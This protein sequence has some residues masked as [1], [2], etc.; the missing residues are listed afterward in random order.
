MRIRVEN[1][2]RR[3]GQTL[4]NLS[5]APNIVLFLSPDLGA[6]FRSKS[7]FGGGV[8]TTND[9]KNVFGAEMRLRLPEVH[10]LSV[11][12]FPLLPLKTF[13]GCNNI[14]TN[15][16]HMQIFTCRA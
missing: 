15:R 12:R 11:Y 8:L 5:T 3:Q 13:E 14:C 9:E 7:C 1:M 16:T 6:A 4:V 2:A 10:I